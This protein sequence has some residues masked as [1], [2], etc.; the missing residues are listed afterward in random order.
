MHILGKL[1]KLRAEAEGYAVPRATSLETET[2]EEAK[3]LRRE[4]RYVEALAILED[5]QHTGGERTGFRVLNEMGLA[6]FA[7]G[8]TEEAL[9]SFDAALNSIRQDVV[10]ILVNRANVFGAL[11]CHDEA[12]ASAE[13]A[14]EQDP[15][16]WLPYLAAI[17]VHADRNTAEDRQA[18]RDLVQL[19]EKN[20][21]GWTT[22]SLVT[23][24]GDEDADF[25][26]LKRTDPELWQLV[27]GNGETTGVES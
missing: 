14:R 15:K 9:G 22:D 25:R 18:I 13:E 16:S 23:K 5:S 1:G 21:A 24:Y 26:A 12:L 17:A 27:F 6:R 19:L 7:L 4:G 2:V 3:A 20:A 11:G 8:E 10:A